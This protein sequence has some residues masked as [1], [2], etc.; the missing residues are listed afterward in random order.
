MPDT[1][2]LR[3]SALYRSPPW[4]G[5]EQPPFINAVAELDTGLSPRALLEALLAIERNHGRRRDGA[6]WGPRTLD[7]DLLVYGTQR[8]A[9]EGLDVPHPRLAERAFVLLPMVELQPALR[10]PGVGVAAELLACIDATQC[11]RLDET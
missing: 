11:V 10:I 6:R 9:E 2:L 4:G 8:V 3:H 7:L 1:R 5:I